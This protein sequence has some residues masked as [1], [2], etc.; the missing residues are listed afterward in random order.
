MRTSGPAVTVG[1]PTVIVRSRPV[2]TS[3][4][5]TNNGSTAIPAISV[6]TRTVSADG[7]V[8]NARGLAMSMS[9]AADI[10]SVGRRATGTHGLTVRMDNTGD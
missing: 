8:I 7:L 6:H 3:R 4:S 5:V 9:S 2:D 10:P 1:M